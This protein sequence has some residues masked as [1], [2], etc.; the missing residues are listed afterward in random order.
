MLEFAE[1]RWEVVGKEQERSVLPIRALA[2]SNLQNRGG[3]WSAKN[4]KVDSSTPMLE[5]RVAGRWPMARPRRL[6]FANSGTRVLEFTEPSG[7]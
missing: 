5:L 7:L 6:G 3:G 1:P 2:C 4:G